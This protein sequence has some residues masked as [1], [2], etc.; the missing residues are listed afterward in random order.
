MF[1]KVGF[2]LLLPENKLSG[3]PRESLVAHEGKATI[4]YDPDQANVHPLVKG[5]PALVLDERFGGFYEFWGG[6]GAS[7]HHAAAHDL[8]RVG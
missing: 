7:V 2:Y 1:F 6:G 8:V 5:A 3:K 4:R